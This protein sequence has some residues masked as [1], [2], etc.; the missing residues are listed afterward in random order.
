MKV[1]I[2]YWTGSGNT[3]MIADSLFAACMDKG[4]ETNNN[5]VLDAEVET[6]KD[7]DVIMLGCPAMSGEA[8]EEYEFRPFF[9]DLLPHLENKKVVL[10]GSYDW[11][12]GQWMLDW[13]AEVK[14]AGAQLIGSGLAYQWT[15][16]VEQLAEAEKTVE[17]F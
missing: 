11:G 15:P 12:D 6:V 9:D 5:Y 8:L 10:F 7:A 4:Y 14:A 1:E 17:S 16:T 3:Q 13:E 2:V